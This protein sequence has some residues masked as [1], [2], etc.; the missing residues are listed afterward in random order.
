M[1]EIR[2]PE[3]FIYRR[4]QFTGLTVLASAS[5]LFVAADLIC[6]DDRLDFSHR[7]RLGMNH[8]DIDGPRGSIICPRWQ[9]CFIQALRIVI[10]APRDDSPTS[11]RPEPQY[12]MTP[13]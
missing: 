8:L 12:S 10:L 6:G 7:A 3:R 11:T 13:A 2:S 4:V 5:T 9:P 1:R